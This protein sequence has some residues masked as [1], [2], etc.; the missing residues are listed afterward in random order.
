M[1]SYCKDARQEHIWPVRDTER[2]PFFF[3]F[4]EPSEQKEGGVKCGQRS[5]MED[6]ITC[7]IAGYTHSHKKFRFYSEIESHL[8]REVI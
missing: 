8:R 3:F 6:Q 1:R 4:L 5:K 2:K 7:G